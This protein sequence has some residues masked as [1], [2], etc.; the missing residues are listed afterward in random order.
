LR[1]GDRISAVAMVDSANV[2]ENGDAAPL[3]LAGL[4]SVAPEIVPYVSADA[5]EAAAEHADDGDGRSAIDEIM[6]D[7]ADDDGTD[8]ALEQDDEDDGPV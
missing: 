4:S 1:E 3:E 6:D 5:A 7:T 2:G 8:A